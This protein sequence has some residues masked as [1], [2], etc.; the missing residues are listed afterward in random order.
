M[1]KLW[2]SIP[3][4]INISLP[5]LLF[6]TMSTQTWLAPLQT[7][8]NINSQDALPYSLNFWRKEKEKE[9]I[10]SITSSK[11]LSRSSA[12]AANRRSQSAKFQYCITKF[13]S[14]G[15]MKKQVIH[16]SQL[17]WQCTSQSPLMAGCIW[18]EKLGM[19]PNMVH[20]SCKIQKWLA[21]YHQTLLKHSNKDM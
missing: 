15:E 17:Q 3:S 14:L 19:N 4:T 20:A 13:F 16:R 7:Y 5:S 2:R 12:K 10:C 1:T 8:A 9:N 6:L 18:M 11:A 21:N